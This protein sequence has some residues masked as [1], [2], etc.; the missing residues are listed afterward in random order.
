MGA[1]VAIQPDAEFLRS[2]MASGG[3]DLKKCY[4]CAT[5]SVA[6]EHS[7]DDSPFPRKQ[8]IEAQWG[9]KNLLVADRA[10]WL[11]HNCG[12]CTEQCPRGARPGDVLAALRREAIRHF[13]FPGFMG[14]L[15]STPKAL[16]LLFL[17]PALIFAA[18]WLWAPKPAPAAAFEF[19]SVFPIGLLE[20]L[21]FAVSGFALAA[22]VIGVAR[23]A[24]GLEQGE[25]GGMP[26]A[27]V[28]IAAHRGFADCEDSPMRIGHLLMFWGFAG[29]ALVGTVT[30]VGTMAGVLSTPLPLWSP[31]KVFAN[32]AAA[33]ALAGVAV[34]F[35]R[36]A[37][38]PARRSSSTYFDWFFLITLTG[39][40]LTGIASEMFRLVHAGAM[41]AVYFVHLVLVFGLLLYAPYSKFAH[42]AYRTVA[43]AGAR[44]P[45]GRS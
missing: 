25:A 14:S 36:R 12:K 32:L 8:M 6:C 43:L 20:P 17:L 18:V 27:L 23:F 31:L 37:G 5:C 41:Y 39:V 21:F 13:S 4:Q 3:G 10:L 30:G 11:C 33:A 28:E 1:A 45:R 40:V 34:L 38:N 22:F 29:L 7:P 19:G 44:R 26:R 24:R 16:P 15:V 9:L 2:V 42:L 35:L